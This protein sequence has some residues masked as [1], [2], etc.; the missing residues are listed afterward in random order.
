MSG[1]QTRKTVRVK[2][3]QI[4]MNN[5][6]VDGMP[7]CPEEVIKYNAHQV[8]RCAIA[9]SKKDKWAGPTSDQIK[10]ITRIMECFK[11]NYINGPTKKV[12]EEL[13]HC[14]DKIGLQCCRAKVGPSKDL[15][16]GDSYILLYTKPRVYNYNGPFM[17]LREGNSSNVVIISPHDG[18][19]QTSIDT[20]IAFQQSRALAM[21]SN[22]HHK[23]SRLVDFS[24]T[25]ENL[26][27]YAL[28]KLAD[29]FPK[30]VLLNIH[31]MIYNDFILVRSRYEPLKQVF[32]DT[33]LNNTI[34]KRVEPFNAWYDIDTINTPYQLKTEIPVKIHKK[35]P[36]FLAV[37]IN[38]IELNSWAWPTT[39]V[40]NMLNINQIERGEPNDQSDIIDDYALPLDSNDNYD[41]CD[42]ECDNECDCECDSKC[43]SKCDSECDSKCDC[44]CE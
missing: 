34:I 2:C 22:G 33:F 23:W 5:I 44:E 35:R 27:N 28:R 39:T 1:K 30:T 18:T 37:V 26:G 14:A 38:Q 36:G 21:I 40:A 32:I 11:L 7:L 41:E 42:N 31:G 43:D 6:D 17:M 9:Q 15:P 25:R 29:L 20:K 24:K 10:N 13:M 16:K 8:L 4:D 12:T 19:D 3:P